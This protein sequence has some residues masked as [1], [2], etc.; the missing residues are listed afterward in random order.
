MKYANRLTA[1]NEHSYAVPVRGGEP[2]RVHRALGAR[3]S[4]AALRAA[5]RKA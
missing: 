3:N 1:A 5:A 2:P 4:T